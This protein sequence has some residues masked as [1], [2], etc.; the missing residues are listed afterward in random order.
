ML[1]AFSLVSDITTYVG[2]RVQGKQVR[3][4]KLEELADKLHVRFHC[5]HSVPHGT[6]L[7]DSAPLPPACARRIARTCA[8]QCVW[9]NG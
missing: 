5:T 2:I 3:A 7:R 4:Q 1:S 8:S 6:H 9:R